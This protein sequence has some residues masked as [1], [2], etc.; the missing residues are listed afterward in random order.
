M[1]L[2]WSLFTKFNNARKKVT[3]N[4]PRSDTNHTH[5]R[6]NREEKSSPIFAMRSTLVVIFVYLSL[7]L[8]FVFHWGPNLFNFV[9][10]K[11]EV[12]FIKSLIVQI[13]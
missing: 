7:F 6:L 5:T 2:I 3:A 10:G 4:P 1:F 12:N 9:S 11:S 8:F 13:E